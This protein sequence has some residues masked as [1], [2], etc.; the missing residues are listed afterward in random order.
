MRPCPVLVSLIAFV[1]FSAHSLTHA[2]P[3]GE[4]WIDLF[5]GKNFS[6]WYKYLS[7]KPRN[8]DPN[9]IFTIENGA[10][11]IY[12]RTKDQGPA[13]LGYIA[14]EIDYSHY[15]LRFQYKWG[16]KRFGSRAQD[17]RDSGLMYHGVGPDGVHQKTW[18]RC[19]EYQVQEGDTGD[20]ICIAGA[21]CTVSIDPNIPGRRRV[22]GQYLPPEDGGVPNTSP[23]WSI[24]SGTYDTLEG[25][26]KVDVIVMGSDYAVYMVNGQINHRLTRIEQ[27]TE[28]GDWT[29]LAAG[30]IMLQAELAEVFFRN[31]QIKPIST[32]PFRTKGS[33]IPANPDGTFT[34]NAATATTSGPQVRFQPDE[35]GTLGH[36]HDEEDQA[37]W[38]ID[39]QKPGTY[40]FEID[41]AIDNSQAGKFF[42]VTAGDASFD[43]RVPGT[44]GWWTYKTRIFGKLDLKR[45]VH[46]LN[47]KAAKEFD[48]AMIDIKEARLLPVDASRPLV[49]AATIYN[50]AVKPRNGDIQKAH[51]DGTFKLPAMH[52]TLSGPQLRFQ[53]D[54][55]DTL[56]WWVHE[57]D[58]ARW[59]IQVDK[60]GKY[61]FE[62]DWSVDDKV[63]GNKIGVRAGKSS[64]EATVPGT[65]GWH[66]YKKKVFGHLDLEAGIQ[67][68]TIRSVG[69]INGAVLD[70]RMALLIP[71]ETSMAPRFQIPDGFE[72]K[73]VAGPPLIKHPMMVCMDE[74]GRL[75]ISESSGINR[76]SDAL[77]K[78][79]PHK[80]LLVED[81]DG[82][83]TFDKSK[84]FADNVVLPNGGTW[85]DNS[86]YVCSAPH[87]WRF[88]DKD[89]DGHAEHRERL[90][91]NFTFTGM[92]DSLHGPVLGPD[93]RLYF[94]GGQHGWTLGDPDT[95]PAI[96][97]NAPGVF[98]CWPD[99]SEAEVLA[100]GGFH[101]P[102]EVS[103]TPEGEVFGTVAYYFRNPVRRDA[104]V[105][106]IYGGVYNLNP[107]RYS[108]VTRTGDALFPMS[109]RG[110]VAPA[111]NTRYRG[112]H[113]GPEYRDNFF[114]AEFNTHKLHRVTVERN[115]ATFR[116]ENEVF[117]NSSDADVH[118]TDVMED[119]DGSLLVV[120][121]GGWYQWGCPTSQIEKPDILGGIYRITRIGAPHPDDPRG[122]KI[123]WQGAS[124]RELAE[125]LDDDR[126]VVRDRAIAALAKHDENAIL[127]LLKTLADG[128]IRARRNA[129]WTLTRI[130]SPEARRAVRS[131]L[132]DSEFSI[133]LTATRSIATRRDSEAASRLLELLSDN[134]PAVRREAATALGRIGN[135]AA[136]TALI[137][138]LRSA[139]EDRFLE[140]A[141]IYALMELGNREQTLPGLSDSATHVRRGALVALDTMR[142]GN[143]TRE[144]VAPL[145]DTDDNALQQ[146]A[147]EVISRHPSWADEITHLLDKWLLE[148]EITSDR[149]SA[150]RGALLAFASDAGVQD[151]VSTAIARPETSTA[152]RLLLL[153]VIARSRLAN[154]PLSWIEQIHATLLSDNMRV[155]RQAIATA[156]SIDTREFDRTI[157]T[158]ARDTSRPSDVRVAAVD[159][160]ADNGSP[161]TA[162]LYDLLVARCKSDVG[163]VERLTAA[164]ALGKARLDPNQLTRLAGVVEQA[165]ALELSPLIAAFEQTDD[166]RIGTHL[167]NTLSKSPGLTSLPAARLASLLEKYP[168]S[169]RSTAA[170]LLEQLEVDK[171]EQAARLAEFDETLTGG[172]PRNGREIFA[173]K[174][175]ACGA[176]HTVGEKGGNIGPNLS[177][178]GKI[179][180]R[181]DVLEAIIFPSAS[182]ARG[183]EPITVL[184]KSGKVIGGTI[185]RETAD[186]LVVRTASREGFLVRRSEIMDLV[187]S[188]VSV[189]PQGLD[190]MLSKGEVRDLLAYLE[191]LK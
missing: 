121:T 38:T 168:D 132:S 124:P 139:K 41:W 152:T 36:W 172:D 32:G 113:F 7:G 64:F 92:S 91:G 126:F 171:S 22:R 183:Y 27:Q 189:M 50:S 82:D 20:I 67:Q 165:G 169:V 141:V 1:V 95:D 130:D 40:A 18:P 109:L 28:S 75:F 170:P 9:E 97:S 147:L 69:K 15:H 84:V 48:G 128:S 185:G 191:S 190:K 99:G 174:K 34:L 154:L 186:A 5:N 6:G 187:P 11:H 70:V 29:P 127:S 42:R 155:V 55:N 111:G 51:A 150:I 101:N 57:D 143:L 103:F 59:S 114:L 54:E 98:S 181:K 122:M 14:T 182:F 120:D 96:E 62:L 12:K 135:R 72:M 161:L 179:R 73:L 74:R 176:C 13:P 87:L 108:K 47:I 151:L 145:L 77:L 100:H 60:P 78:E 79:R 35:N 58:Q 153:E 158:L 173:D 149:Q 52:A 33:P 23:F 8:H 90:L 86:L 31:I 162:D 123:D 115:G 137:M 112:T 119:A 131:A 63:A 56:G 49:L 24:K 110:H 43:A 164:R 37:S 116:T 175:A 117:I 125:L 88:D 4:G 167:V 85:I 188:Q 133:R 81:S 71:I 129:I 184:T 136:T 65:G 53:P 21:R 148:E 104:F 163:A 160:I 30:R 102:V 10:L 105:H 16:K 61:V 68:V 180:T 157:V 89:D 17:K 66:T 142:N 177:Q 134:E 107:E 159:V 39:V 80:I 140:H 19:M 144:L 166:A 83:G 93:G 46:E 45:G 118:F 76:K 156:A 106:W 3:K 94:C 26:N 146:T 138:A 25:W 44:G 2:G 178:I